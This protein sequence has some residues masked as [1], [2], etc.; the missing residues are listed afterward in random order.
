MAIDL[1]EIDIN[2]DKIISPN[3]FGRLQLPKELMG[4]LV[5]NPKLFE[6]Q[7]N[8]I[9]AEAGFKLD[10]RVIPTLIKNAQQDEALYNALVSNFKPLYEHSE[11]SAPAHGLSKLLRLLT[12]PS[13]HR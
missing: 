8:G 10:D 5:K 1:K 9:F 11:G 4:D 13:T 6:N 3:E 7:V 12:Q 2:G